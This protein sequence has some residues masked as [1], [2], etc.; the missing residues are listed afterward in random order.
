MSE[1]QRWMGAAIEAGRKLAVAVRDYNKGRVT[2]RSVIVAL[3]GWQRAVGVEQTPLP[4][5]PPRE[6]VRRA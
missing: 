4:R 5:R 1:Q 3:R 2:W 6:R